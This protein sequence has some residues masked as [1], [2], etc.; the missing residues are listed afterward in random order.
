[1]LEGLHAFVKGRAEGAIEWY[2]QAKS[3]KKM[4][5]IRLRALSILLVSAAAVIPILSQM[6]TNEQGEQVIA[7]AWA[8]VALVIAAML[9]ALDRLLGCSS[10]WIRYIS[11]EFRL[12]KLLDEFQSGRQVLGCW[13]QSWDNA[14]LKAL[15]FHWLKDCE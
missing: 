1:M 2:L 8:S 4:W 14:D 7:P 13:R 5:A 9:V 11:T 6:I 3:R 15:A 10:S 12:Q